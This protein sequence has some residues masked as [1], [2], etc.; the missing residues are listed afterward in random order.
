MK[1]D[2]QI[3]EHATEFSVYFTP[4]AGKRFQAAL[5]SGIG[6]VD[7]EALCALIQLNGGLVFDLPP[8]DPYKGCSCAAIVGL[9][10][11]APCRVHG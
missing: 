4:E 8:K 9:P 2:I 6:R 7:G 5:T 11:A 3:G 1:I 10:H